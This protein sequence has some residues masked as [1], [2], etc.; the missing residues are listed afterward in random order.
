MPT[1]PDVTT[2]IAQVDHPLKAEIAAL[3]ALILGADRRIQESIKWNAPSFAI[4]EHFATFKL[5][6]RE[7]LQI[8]FHTGAKKRTPSLTMSIVD[9]AGPA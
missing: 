4:G 1:K 2:F 3:R 6:P 7:T 9:S 8:I 5:H